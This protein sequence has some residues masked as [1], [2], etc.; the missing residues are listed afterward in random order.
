MGLLETLAGMAGQVLQQQQGG[1]NGLIEAALAMLNN[2][3]AQ[4]GIEGLVRQFTQAG[5]GDQI[6]SW[7]GTGTNLPV[8]GNDLQQALGNDQLDA[9]ARQFGGSGGEIAGQLAQVLPG[10]V[11]KLTPSGQIPAGGFDDALANLSKVLRA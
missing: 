11:D 8:S 9:L 4:G 2:G 5:L 7:I 6:Q 10:L 1:N 3:S